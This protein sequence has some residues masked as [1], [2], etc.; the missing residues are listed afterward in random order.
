MTKSCRAVLPLLFWLVSKTESQSSIL[1]AGVVDS[2]NV[3]GRRKN[4]WALRLVPPFLL[5]NT[6]TNLQN[7]NGEGVPRVEG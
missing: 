1:A 7:S 5:Q 3:R 6:S 4:G 2:T